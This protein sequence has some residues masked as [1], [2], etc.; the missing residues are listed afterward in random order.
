MTARSGGVNKVIAFSGDLG[1]TGV[2]LMND[3]TPLSSADLVIMESTYGDRDHRPLDA[4]LEEMAAILHDAI[5]AK[6]KVLVPAFAVGRSQ[7]VIHYLGEFMSTGRTPSF[8]VFLDSPMAG[9][10][11]E[12]YRKHVRTL[13][14]AARDGMK[15]GEFSLDIP[16]LSC[17]SSKEESKAINDVPGA[18]VII[19]GSGM[20]TGG[21]ILHHLR[22]NLWRK[23]T[24]VFIMGFQAAGSLGR[25]LVERQRLVRVLG[26]NVPVRAKVH[27]LGGFSAHAGRTDLLA[28]ASHFA[29]DASG[30]LPSFVLNHGEDGPRLKLAEALKAKGAR[31]VELPIYGQRIEL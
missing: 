15:R 17:T 28:W 16:N 26:E 12:L 22:H 2:P 27:T 9:K 23:D 24:H 1:P 6:Q 14:A 19:A 18:A 30:R 8:P 13:D 25:R 5:W 21:R 20:C 4:T 11:M 29:T 3:P 10:A 7:L 31:S